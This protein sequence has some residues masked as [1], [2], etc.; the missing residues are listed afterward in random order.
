MTKSNTFFF[1]IKGSDASWKG[2]SEVPTEFVDFS[3]DEAEYAF[4][5]QNVNEQD[6]FDKKRKRNSLE[7]HKM[8]ETAMNL[9]NKVDT[10]RHK[11]KDTHEP[12]PKRYVP[13]NN[14]PPFYYH[15]TAMNQ[16]RQQCSTS[17][18]NFPPPNFVTPPPNF[19]FVNM[20]PPILNVPP[21]ANQ[22]TAAMPPFPPNPQPFPPAAYGPPAIPP[23]PS[24]PHVLPQPQP[25]P[26]TAPMPIMPPNMNVMNIPKQ[27]INIPKSPKIPKMQQN[28]GVVPKAQ[29]MNVHKARNQG[30]PKLY[31][32]APIEYQP[33]FPPN[34]GLPKTTVSP[35]PTNPPPNMAVSLPAPFGPP[36]PPWSYNIARA[37]LNARGF[38]PPHCA[39]MRPYKKH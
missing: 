30:L 20:G 10:A 34:L 18:S 26:F 8:Y 3:D 21:Y 13:Q 23:L 17:F 27:Q 22:F 29:L 15:P 14:H 24:I 11:M 6:M 38:Q 32:P 9:R 2:D 5:K 19:G 16:M 4:T 31:I 7:K 36:M 28:T 1:R 37:P 39:G 25:P 33:P 12:T 35:F